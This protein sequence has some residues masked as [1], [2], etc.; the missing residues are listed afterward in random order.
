MDCGPSC[1]RIIS[2]FYGKNIPL[3]YL[4]TLCDTQ[5]S[6][7]SLLGLTEASEALGFTAEP[8]TI[9]Y[10]DLNDKEYFPCIAY[11]NQ[12]HFV[13]IYRI[14]NNKVYV[15]DPAHGLLQYKK[16]DF[17]K[18]WRG[19]NETGVV[20]LLVPE[21]KFYTLTDQSA[22]QKTGFTWVL[23]YYKGF[24]NLIIKVIV[25]LLL[26]SAIQFVLPFLTQQIVD[27]G[28]K[29]KDLSFIN[30]LLLGQL[31]LFAG[32]I[33]ADVFRN[34]ISLKLSTRINI[35]MINAFFK[36][37][38]KL[39]AGFFDN[40]MTGDILQRINDHQRVESFLSSG[41]LNILFAVVNIILFGAV[42]AWYSVLVFVVFAAGS[43]LYFIWGWYF[44]KQRAAMD[45]KRFSSLSENQDKNIE[46]IYGMQE[47][48]LNNAE[49]KK[50]S[51]WQAL[52]EK[53][54]VINQKSLV[55]RQTQTAG[56]SLIN[57]LKNILITFL[58]AKLVITHSESFT[59]GTMLA[60]SYIIG[61][62]NGPVSQ[63]L[64]FLQTWQDAQLSV[65]RI[66]EI[67]SKKDESDFVDKETK[68]VPNN[69]NITVYDL[70]FKYSKNKQAPD[71][72]NGISFTIPAGKITAIV[73]SSGSGKTTLMKL[74]LRY[75][76][77]YQGTITIG[78]NALNSISFKDW[79]NYCGA[80][81]QEGFIFSDTILNNIVMADVAADQAKLNNA[82]HISN[83]TQF[84]K[85]LPLG[86]HTKIGQ[87]GMGMSTGQ[88]QRILI[89]R[90][91]YKDPSFI[92]F[93]EAT[94]ALD[95]KNEKEI[96]D[97]LNS[98]FKNK[99]VLI[100]AHRL[101]TVKNA[102]NIIVL[103]NGAITEQG[104]HETLSAAKG[105]YYHLVRNQL[106]VG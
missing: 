64:E 81:L 20:L 90:A 10:D 40:K 55:I 52:Q 77:H 34:Y 24:K 29:N 91:V 78:G 57:E 9:G 63:I 42:L 35:N 104:T 16:E 36:K 28:I 60:V 25:S 22:T 56:A 69:A 8:I 14:S 85:D 31:A 95:A 26:G 19:S 75:Y 2:K 39:P 76:T 97:K 106:E 88:K 30:L 49:E 92:L 62:L 48:K 103:E 53:L 71:I 43:I 46:L 21:E 23:N 101:S 74:L 79:R 93:D 47:I 32:R 61:Q 94:S 50:R 67:H 83:L 6:G 13:V 98:Y 80:V 51:Q 3:D 1:L 18:Y 37:L 59:L 12:K 82:L 102:D 86:L 41:I 7:T 105:G 58:A 44:M 54:F 87:N 68:A 99:T 11:C 89:A 72:L 4:R 65:S 66:N 27:K 45:Y 73:G 70:N 100:I 15:S 5:R 33:F 17:E 84:V 96:W 38:M